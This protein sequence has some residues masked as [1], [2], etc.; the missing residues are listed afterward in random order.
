MKQLTIFLIILFYSNV[1]SQDIKWNTVTKNEYNPIQLIS[2]GVVTLDNGDK[3]PE[4]DLYIDFA[5]EIIFY[6]NIRDMNIL[7]VEPII[8]TEEVMI[9][10]QLYSK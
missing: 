9:I 2:R 3:T 10:M 1:S 6:R 5:G 7:Q 4:A 8:L